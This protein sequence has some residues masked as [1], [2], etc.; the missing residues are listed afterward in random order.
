MIETKRLL[1]RPMHLNDVDDL[2]HI[3]TDPRVMSSF[4]GELFDHEQMER[5]V[6]S[7]LDHQER[8]GYGLFSIILKENGL[9]IGDSGLEH[10]A[11]DGEVQ[12]ELGYDL[13]SD[14]WGRGL[15]TEAASAVRD[16]AFGTLDIPRL[17]SLIRMGNGAS[18]RVAE[19]VGMSLEAEIERYGRPY[20]LYALSRAEAR[21]GRP[22]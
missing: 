21:P 22:D 13:R 14:Y 15:A 11:I 20:W 9:L 18:R 7:N 12:A 19:K 6:L 2:L 1:L 5:W 8:H 17:V 10:M 3:F 16:Y 4:D